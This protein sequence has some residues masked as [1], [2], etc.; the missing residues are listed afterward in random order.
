MLVRPTIAA[1]AVVAVVLGACGGE[2]RA[3]P[4]CSSDEPD[5]TATYAHD[6]VAFA[7]GEGGWLQ[8][9][10]TGGRLP[11]FAK[12]GLYVRGRGT[13][14]IRVP[15]GQRHVRISGWGGRAGELKTAVLLEASPS[16]ARDWTGYP[17]GLAFS[18][19][20]CVR[21]RVEGPGN[22][23]GSARFGLRREC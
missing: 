3:A 9:E 5:A 23:I 14:V 17:G 7:T 18:G 15:E 21:L 8:A 6:A 16:C 2:E 1:A 20:R 22:A 11:W 10:R 13:V 19:R 4:E 12:F